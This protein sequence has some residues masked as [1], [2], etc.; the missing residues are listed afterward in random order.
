MKKF[1]LFITLL[2][3]LIIVTACESDQLGGDDPHFSIINAIYR[4]TNDY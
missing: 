1:E 2:I 4:T 3:I